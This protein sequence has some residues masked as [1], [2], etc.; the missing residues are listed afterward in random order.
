MDNWTEENMEKAIE[1]VRNGS[2]SQRQAAFTFGVPRTTLNDRILGKHNGKHGRET[3]L[4]STCET[5]LV[6]LLLFMSDIGFAMNKLQVIDTIK[7]YLIESNQTH[8]FKDNEPTDRWYYGFLERHK[9]Q[10]KNKF[11]CKVQSLRAVMTQ[12][13]IFD[14]WFQ[15]GNFYLTKHFLNNIKNANLC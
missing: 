14:S 15:K 7:N 10:L 5:L 9:E 4:S 2:M 8:I 13:E 12:P 6:T 3:L 11:A 1:T